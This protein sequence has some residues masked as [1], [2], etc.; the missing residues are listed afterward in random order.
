MGPAA[1]RCRLGWSLLP[2]P[3]QNCPFPNV[4]T[5]HCRSRISVSLRNIG[6]DPLPRRVRG[7]G[8]HLGAGRC[9]AASSRAWCCL[10]RG[11][12]ARRLRVVN[13][14]PSGPRTG[15]RTVTH[16]ARATLHPRAMQVARSCSSVARRSNRRAARRAAQEQRSREQL[17]AQNSMYAVRTPRFERQQHDRGQRCHR[18]HARRAKE[19]PLATIIAIMHRF[20]IS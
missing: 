8:C 19:E 17:R 14:L 2:W 13:T 16:E 6:I 5:S 9:T 1:A 7:R 11:A 18:E 15:R 3:A 10:G 20:C 4:L 12:D